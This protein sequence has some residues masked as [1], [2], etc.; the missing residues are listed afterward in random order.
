[1]AAIISQARSATGVTGCERLLGAT[2]VSSQ[3]GATVA[4][5]VARCRS[6]QSSGRPAAPAA[7]PGGGFDVG[8]AELGNDTIFN[9][10]FELR[11]SAGHQAGRW[12][13][14]G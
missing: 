7:W 12:V 5:A 2:A 6:S 4:R 3:P 1:M 11:G 10:M 9:A 8:G 14:R 13:D